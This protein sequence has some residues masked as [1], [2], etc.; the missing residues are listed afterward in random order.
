MSYLEIKKISKKFGSFTALSDINFELKEGEFLCLLGPSGCGKT[1]LLR[2]IAGLE[3]PD[4]GSVI[5][6]G[7]DITYLHPSLRNF[8]IVFQSYALFPNMNVYE[9]ISFGLK[10]KKFAKAYVKN[11]VEELISLVKLNH[12]KFK[13]P[14][15]ISGGEQQRVA[16]ARAL[17]LNPNFLLLDEPLSALDAKV[18]NK[19]REEIKETQKKLRI[20]TIMVTH[21]QEEALTMADRVVVM[22][23]G[24]IMQI[25]TPLSVYE[26][27]ADPF[28]ADFIGEINFIKE[29]SHII[30]I[31][32]ENIRFGQEKGL[33]AELIN[34]E[35][36]GA[37]YRLTFLLKNNNQ[38]IKVDVPSNKKIDFENQLKKFYIELPSEKTISYMQH[39]KDSL[40]N[41]YYS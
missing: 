2:I 17:A 41:S 30:A 24:R 22:N 25:D 36:R 29:N 1:T 31:R 16:L 12:V 34:R 33:E 18:R 26:M 35:F 40:D 28:V 19:L 15:Q 32:P 14:F 7:K 38:F 9:N 21:D 20:T 8:G 10:N 13:Y 11:R 37:F 4:S 6:N 39:E 5:L 3:E 27:P 23:K